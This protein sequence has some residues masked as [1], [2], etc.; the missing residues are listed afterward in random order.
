[1]PVRKISRS[2]GSTTGVL[3]SAHPG[4]GQHAYES[5]LERDLFLRLDFDPGVERFEAQPVRIHYEGPQGKKRH[6]T[7]DTLAF[8]REG[9]PY[10]GSASPEHE[11][12]L[13]EVK[14]AEELREK[15]DKLA[16]KFEA[17]RSYASGR[18]WRFEVAT[19]EEIRTPFL[20]NA[21]LLR[22]L[23]GQPVQTGSKEIRRILEIS[24]S[25]EAPTADEIARRIFPHAEDEQDA[26][27]AAANREKARRRVWHLLAR[28]YFEAD[29]HSR[30]LTGS[31]PLKRTSLRTASTAEASTHTRTAA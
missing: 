7:P 16:P 21:R 11:A 4:G 2:R 17:A 6:Y 19:E 31:T 3:T 13:Y 22:K 24:E 8:F 20:R 10:W 9:G 26:T 14:Y 5:G 15:R 29:L 25:L 12:A 23:A 30:V 28:G 1:M 18:G 27:N